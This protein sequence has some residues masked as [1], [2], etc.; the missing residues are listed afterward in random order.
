MPSMGLQRA[1]YD[2]AT[3]QQNSCSNEKH[4]DG[5]ALPEA[6]SKLSIKWSLGVGICWEIHL[7]VQVWSSALMEILPPD[8]LTSTGLT[9]TSIKQ[10]T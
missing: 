5:R 6:A 10:N 1:G 7:S 9:E 8:G 2:L 3:E 4:E